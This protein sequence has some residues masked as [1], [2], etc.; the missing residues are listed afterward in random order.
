MN[1]PMI[2]LS[3]RY[4]ILIADMFIFSSAYQFLWPFFS[5]ALFQMWM[6]CLRKPWRLFISFTCNFNWNLKLLM[7]WNRLRGTV[8]KK[9]YDIAFP[10]HSWLFLFI[11]RTTWKTTWKSQTA[12]YILAGSKSRLLTIRSI[13]VWF[14]HTVRTMRNQCIRNFTHFNKSYSVP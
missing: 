13:C 5:G 6:I 10:T 12:I 8:K 14:T 3:F 1:W 9:S 4:V 2:S 11:E 7:R